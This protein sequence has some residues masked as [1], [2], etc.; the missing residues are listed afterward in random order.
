[1]TM[2]FGFV[3]WAARVVLNEHSRAPRMANVAEKF[4]I[5]ALT[6]YYDA[7]RFSSTN[8]GRWRPLFWLLFGHGC[9]HPPGY[10]LGGHAADWAVGDT[11]DW[12]SALQASDSVAPL[13]LGLCVEKFFYR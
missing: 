8:S 7:V 12:Q 13:G 4:R 1:M 9:H 11:A 3:V 6:C 2:K 5:V 10:T